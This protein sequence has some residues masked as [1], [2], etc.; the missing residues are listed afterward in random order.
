MLTDWEGP[1]PHHLLAYPDLSPERV[2]DASRWEMS[3]GGALTSEGT[4]FGIGEERDDLRG[5]RCTC[6]RRFGILGTWRE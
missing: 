5:T 3:G 6:T 2:R 4:V 1:R